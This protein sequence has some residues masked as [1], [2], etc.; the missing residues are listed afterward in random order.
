[1]INLGA[2]L[3]E[4]RLV[5]GKVLIEPINKESLSQYKTESGIT[6]I[7]SNHRAKRNYLMGKI[8]KLGSRV[9]IDGQYIELNKLFDV[10]DQIFYYE[11]GPVEVSI[12]DKTYLIIRAEDIEM[13]VIRED[14]NE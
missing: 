10:G 11:Y 13:A 4:F 14:D 3:D 5:G 6:V 12:N 9:M 1:M 8:I 7:Q 2:S